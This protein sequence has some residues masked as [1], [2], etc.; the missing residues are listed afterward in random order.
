MGFLDTLR[1][2]KAA[3]HERN[4]EREMFR[5]AVKE[6]AKREGRAAYAKG[7]IGAAKKRARKAG[8]EEYARHQTRGSAV[9][10]FVQGLPDFS[11]T[12]SMN[13]HQTFAA[14]YLP[15]TSRAED[16]PFYLFK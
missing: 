3:A 4:L 1:K 11:D 16:D 5:S 7:Y 15:K 14:P 6:E 9:K 12:V 13:V 8:I 10:K 2:S